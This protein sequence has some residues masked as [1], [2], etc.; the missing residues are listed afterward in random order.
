MYTHI[1]IFLRVVTVLVVEKTPSRI[2]ILDEA[3]CISFCGNALGKGT[4]LSV[5]SPHQLWVNSRTVI[6]KLI[7][8]K[9]FVVFY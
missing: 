7:L 9:K 4:N 6:V 3:V 5:L 8:L 1:H 2:Q